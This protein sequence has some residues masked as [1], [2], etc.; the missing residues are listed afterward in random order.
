MCI[1][2][3][4]RTNKERGVYEEFQCGKCPVCLRNRVNGW[5]F[6]LQK[7]GDVSDISL[8]VTLTYDTDYV[9]MTKRGWMT[10]YKKDLQDFFK[11]LRKNTGKK[12]KYYAVGEYGT[13]TYRPHY[14]LIL[15][16][17]DYRDVILAWV[18]G[19]KKGVDGKPIGNVHFGQVTGASIAYTLKYMQKKKVIPMHKNDDRIPEFSLMS[20]GLGISY[21]TKSVIKWHK[22]DIENRMY[23]SF[24]GGQKTVMPRYYR[25]KLYDEVE[26][27]RISEA[28]KEKIYQKNL[29]AEKELVSLYG[30][31]DVERVRADYHKHLFTKMYNDEK[32][33]RKD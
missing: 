5:S 20:Q 11:R 14:H 31:E 7:E 13:R 17:A 6:R 19:G 33:R 27:H 22:K 29:E 3:F 26:R 15:F 8:F 24:V 16:N 1:T 21:L 18:K 10:L 23:V 25:N 12:I 32:N 28:M 4:K 2:P 30:K 9:P